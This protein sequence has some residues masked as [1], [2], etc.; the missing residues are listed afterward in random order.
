[1]CIEVPDVIEPHLSALNPGA[2]CVHTI[3]PLSATDARGNPGTRHIPGW[4]G[5]AVMDA[6]FF[7]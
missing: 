1:M 3:A 4:G 6:P 5:G 7:P 2:F